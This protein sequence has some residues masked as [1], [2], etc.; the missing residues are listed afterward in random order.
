MKIKKFAKFAT[1]FLLC[2]LLALGFLCFFSAAWYVR[3]YGRIGFDSILYTLT[4][5]LTGLQSGIIQSYVTGAALPALLCTAVSGLLLLRSAPLFRKIRLFSMPYWLRCTLCILITL[6]LIVHAA[7]NVQLVDYIYSRHTAS[8][9]YEYEYHAPENTTI[10]FPEQKRNLVY[11]ILESMETSYLSTEMGGGLDRNLIPE[12]TTLAE[13]NI[14][15]SHNSTVGGFRELPGS[16]WTIA[17]MVCQTAGVPLVTPPD[18]DGNSYG[19]DGSFLPGITTLTDILHE[20][21]YYQALMVG[22]DANFGGRKPYYSAHGVDVVYDL[23]TARQ[24]GVIPEDYFVWWGMEDK[25]LF[26]YAKQELLELADGDAPFAFTLLT[27]DTHHI[28]GYRCEYC[29]NDGAEQY[30]DVISCSSKQVLSFVNWLQQQD[31]YENTTVIITGDHNSMDNGYFSRRISSNYTR[32]VYNCF[33]NSAVEPVKMKDRLFGAIDM[34]PTTLA[35]M[36]CEIQGE[37]LGLGTN[38]FSNMPTLAEKMGYSALGAELSNRSE[39]YENNF[40]SKEN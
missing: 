36:G 4:A 22:S 11:I 37:R 27:V 26:N 28:G 14:N 40:Y 24:D 31:F 10:S 12:L 21:G 29:G 33:L 25:H 1:N 23:Y 16:S 7:F 18:I 9:I 8:S 2:L 39:Y 17:S 3:V 35:A 19:Q 15:F 38:L 5:S 30:E 34:F 6:L 32:H 13:E 20:N